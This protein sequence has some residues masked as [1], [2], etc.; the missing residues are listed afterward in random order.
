MNGLEIRL[1]RSITILM[2]GPK[3]HG[4]HI[5]PLQ[6]LT[7]RIWDC[8]TEMETQEGCTMVDNFMV[9]SF[10]AKRLPVRLVDKYKTELLRYQ[11]AHGGKKPGL[12][13]FEL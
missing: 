4:E 5:K 6:S 8:T 13:W 10:I 9:V 7:D 2:H 12:D 11:D 1:V 3:L